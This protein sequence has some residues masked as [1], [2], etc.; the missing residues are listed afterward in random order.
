MHKLVD[1]TRTLAV[2]CSDP[3]WQ[4]G[5]RTWNGVDCRDCRR[6]AAGFLSEIHSS[7]TKGLDDVP[8]ETGTGFRPSRG[9]E[10][11]PAENDGIS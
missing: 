2:Y 4:H 10:G 8:K 7:L 9:H 3:E 1:G 5:S 6:I 11:Q